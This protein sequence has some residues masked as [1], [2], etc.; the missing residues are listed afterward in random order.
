MPLIPL[1]PVETVHLMREVDEALI[2]LLEGLEP[3]DWLR[4]AVGH[5]AVR[6]VVAHLLDGAVRRLSLD[7]DGYRPLA[8]ALDLTEYEELVAHLN[9]L[10]A[11]WVAAAERLS[12]QVMV[13]LLEH[14]CPQVADH[15]E[16]LDPQ[17]EASFPVSWAAEE[18]SR[19]W[20][21]VAREFTER[22][23][24]QQQ[25]REAVGAD[26][27]DTEHY[28]RPLLEILVRALPRAYSE[29]SAPAGTEIVVRILDLDDLGWVL[30][31]EVDC[32]QL[33]VVDRDFVIQRFIDIPASAAWRLFT[34][35]I[36]GEEAKRRART[37]GEQELI[38]PFFTTLAVMA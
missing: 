15:F 38:D 24:H 21:D 20:M 13:D 5:W 31:R 9:D 30:R 27:L 36:T 34:R 28:V 29:A 8:P 35:G 16:S 32:W 33:W 18:S 4:P 19:V 3:E 1:E 23:H 37:A 14:V 26:G 22:W 2:P 6:D 17:A 12:P 10:N 25:I 7:R 11:T